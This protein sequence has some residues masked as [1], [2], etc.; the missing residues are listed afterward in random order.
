MIRI[1]LS[2]VALGLA[3][4]VMMFPSLW[5]AYR[6]PNPS[7]IAPG[8][9]WVGIAEALLWGFYGWHHAD[10]GVITFAITALVG[11]A[12]MLARYRATRNRAAAA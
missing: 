10:A 3:F 9:W 4:G 8:T 6:T 5:V 2:F 1:V 11:S 12:A 7:G